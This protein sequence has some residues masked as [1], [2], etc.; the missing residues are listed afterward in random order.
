MLRRLRSALALLTGRFRRDEMESRMSDE[1]R[2]HIE[3]A[4]ERHVR[5]GLL[6]D[7]ARRLAL[8][9]FGPRDA[10]AEDARDEYRSRHVEQV[11]QDVRYALRNLRHS[12]SFTVTAVFTL[13]LCIGATTS[14]FSVVNAVLLR[15]LPYPQPDRIA[16]LCELNNEDLAERPCNSLNPGNVMHWQRTSRAFEAIGAMRDA[17]VTIGIPGD[18]PLSAMARVANASVFQILGASAAVGR[19]FTVAE[20]VEGGPDL[21]VLSH[22]FW[23]TQFGGD[24]SVIGR[25]VHLNTFPYTVVGVAARDVGI[26]DPVDL[27]VPLRFQARQLTA[28]GRFLRGIGRLRDGV[29]I[30]QAED[31]LARMAADRARELP[32]SNAN[33]TAYAMPL[34]ERLIGGSRR[35]LWVLL[36]A[37]G[38]LLVIACANVANLQ[39]V[40]A[41][42]RQREVALRISLGA[43]PGRVVR[44]LLTEGLVLSIVASA[45]GFA[46]AI[47]G[48]SALVALVPDD[49]AIHSLER[50][51][52]DGMVLAFTAIVAAVSGILF[53]M[54]PAWQAT[55]TDVQGVLKDGG[56]GSGGAS[57]ASARLRAGLVVAEV[58]LALML[59]AGAGL[60]VRSFSAL[61]DVRLGFDPANALAARVTVPRAVYQTDTQVVNFF[62]DAEARVAASP[63]VRSVG[64]ISF[65]PLSGDRSS[66]GFN[67][68]GRP[69]AALGAEP[70]GDM[71]AVTPGY[72]DAMGIAITRGRG[73]TT[74]DGF[75]TPKVGVISET[76]ARTMFPAENPIGRFLIYEWAEMERVEIVGVAADVHHNAVDKAPFMEIY[77]PLAQFPYSAMWMVVRGTGDAAMLA[78][79]MR[80]AIRAVDRNV[81]LA[82]VRPLAMMVAESLGRSR[83][84]TAL[85]ALFGGLGL[86]L[87]AVGIYGVMSH[88]VQ[89]RRHEMGVRMALGAS[90]GSVR[91]LVVKRGARLALAG[92]A[93]GTVGALAAT[94]LM[95]KLLFDV[96]PGDPR[97][98][99]ATAAILGAVALLASYIPARA[100]TTVDPMAAL[101]RD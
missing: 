76:L 12:P 7:E 46:L 34:R 82:Q 25:T 96:R 75:G 81:P 84:S 48:T 79:P 16:V 67:V 83:L 20:D 10:V 94:R 68:E 55:R 21:A 17:R 70:D 99:L 49:M 64:S 74:Q 78:Q 41:A 38:F 23:R 86:V 66:N 87:A 22:A 42:A 45:L 18:E 35:V 56:R 1:T 33:W 65:M 62:R 31:E 2:F 80:D 39:L 47:K 6:P 54:V 53:G 88:T 71:R 100:A 43:S 72:F 14:M 3:M 26:H 30:V 77:R 89:L 101:R 61:Q 5:S 58:S 90:P 29:T 15:D 11:V 98:F 36:G 92:I 40:R 51:K 85:F 63:G 57:H 13:V 4:T 97:T 44:Q 52:P 32:E 60:M 95:T 50:V 28:P 8:V 91:G 37:V 93:L 19:L 27:W 24:S 69:P 59:L 73:F 9:E